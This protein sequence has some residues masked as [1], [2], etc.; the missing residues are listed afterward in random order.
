[1]SGELPGYG[2]QI[3]VFSQGVDG[4]RAKIIN[5]I[6][7]A[8]SPANGIYKCG[9][10]GVGLFEADDLA[11]GGRADQH[12]I[13]AVRRAIRCYVAQVCSSDAVLVRNLV[14]TPDC[15]EVLGD[16]PLGGEAE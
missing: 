2:S 9:T 4:C 5:L 14:I 11:P 10:E 3:G 7:T 12:R 15:E 8:E 16:Q 1:M 13:E 6:F